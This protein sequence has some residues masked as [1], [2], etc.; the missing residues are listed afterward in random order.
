MEADGAALCKRIMACL[1]NVEVEAVGAGDIAFR[2]A[3]RKCLQS[4]QV[5]GS[6]CFESPRE[7]KKNDGEKNLSLL[8]LTGDRSSR[9]K[10][11]RTKRCR[12]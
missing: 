12:R 3:L 8:S 6:S 7:K 9:S 1:A 4:A 5:V 2:S 10:S 11:P